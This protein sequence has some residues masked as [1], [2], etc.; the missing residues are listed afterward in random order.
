MSAQVEQYLL[1]RLQIQ[2]GKYI[3]IWEIFHFE[4]HNVGYFI[5][6]LQLWDMHNI[7]EIYNFE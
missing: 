2:A 5:I 7:Q 3:I 1:D 4:F 6:L